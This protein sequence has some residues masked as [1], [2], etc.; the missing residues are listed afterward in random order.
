MKIGV[1]GTGMVGDAIATK[2]VQTGHDVKMGSRD[3]KN[4]KAVAWARKVGPRGSAGTFQDAAKHAEIV[5][6]CT[7]GAASLAVL[8][9]AGEKNLEEK[10][11]VDVCNGLDHSTMPPSLIIDASRDS[12]GEQIQ[13]TFPKTKVIKAF[14]TVTANLMVNPSALP[15]E[16]DLFISGNDDA[17][18]KTFVELIEK[19]FGWKKARVVDLGDITAA[20]AQE[21]LIVPWI[22]LWGRLGTPMFNWHVVA[23]RK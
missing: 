6:N 20:R 19:D 16:H 21:A 15:G 1:L 4:P 23:A 17:A 5:F 18:K 8:K 13:R 14:N 11:L 22:R 12:L 2:L 10:I 7:A 9:S 3:D